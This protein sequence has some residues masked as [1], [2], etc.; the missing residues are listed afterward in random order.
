M[1][2]QDAQAFLAA[3]ADRYSTL[4]ATYCQ[5]RWEEVIVQGRRLLDD[6]EGSDD[7]LATALRLRAQLLMG[8]AYLHGLGNRDA[9]EDHYRL[10]MNTTGAE[11][12]LRRS[13]EEGLQACDRPLAQPRRDTD[14]DAETDTATAGSPAPAEAQAQAQAQAEGS[15]QAMVAAQSQAPIQ[16]EPSRERPQP[17]VVAAPD[18]SLESVSPAQPSQPQEAAAPWIQ[19]QPASQAAPATPLI[20]DLVEEPELLEVRRAEEPDEVQLEA[21]VDRAAAAAAARLL[22]ASAREEALAE[23]GLKARRPA[24]E[25][26]L[27][28]EPSAAAEANQPVPDQPQAEQLRTEQPLTEQ[29]QKEQPAAALSLDKA[30]VVQDLTSA[31]PAAEPLSAAAEPL[32]ELDDLDAME[33]FDQDLLE[34]LLQ[35]TLA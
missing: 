12:A 3:A 6:I 19:A 35:V 18:L 10:V 9:A 14:I 13:A 30:V 33:E 24:A 21:D 1:A 26:V 15:P 20:P 34:G 31:T 4:E 11:P 17:E 25:D 7:P 5:D 23:I 29:P 32:P 2:D 8:H 22:A 28:I 16:A 27:I